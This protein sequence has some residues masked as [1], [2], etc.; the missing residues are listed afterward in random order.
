MCT[1]TYNTQYMDV[2]G[3]VYHESLLPISKTRPNQRNRIGVALPLLFV[4]HY[5]ILNCGN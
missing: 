1:Y 5:W 4:G 3:I 2:Y